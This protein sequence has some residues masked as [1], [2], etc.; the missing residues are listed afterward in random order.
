MKKVFSLSKRRKSQTIPDL[1]AS[2]EL[3]DDA[4]SLSLKNNDD[5]TDKEVV[6][7]LPSLPEVDQWPDR[8][9]FLTTSGTTEVTTNAPDNQ[10]TKEALPLGEPIHFQDELSEG[11]FFLRVRNVG[12]DKDDGYF[13]SKKRTKRIVFQGRVKEPIAYSNVFFGDVYDKP[14]NMGKVAGWVVPIIQNIAPG[15]IMDVLSRKPRI[16]IPIL[17]GCKK[18][19]ICKPGQEPDMTQDFEENT[20][21]AGWSFGSIKERQAAFLKQGKKRGA[22]EEHGAET[23]SFVFDPELIYTMEFYDDV[24]DY[25]SYRVRIPLMGSYPLKWAL[26][27]QPFTIMAEDTTNNRPLFQFRIYHQ[28]QYDSHANMDVDEESPSQQ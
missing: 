26:N 27:N 25:A 16:M 1:E 12:K 28:D 11:T 21:A 15:I 7:A 20:Q 10:S 6:V 23:S 19:H 9:L 8:P 2:S 14:L 3:W 24:I 22:A 17:G 5:E 4:S 18:L 13:A